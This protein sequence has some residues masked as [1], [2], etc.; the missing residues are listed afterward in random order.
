MSFANATNKL[1]ILNIKQIKVTAKWH[2]Q[3]S[4]KHSEANA[5]KYPR[6]FSQSN[7]NLQNENYTDKTF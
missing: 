6:G 5:T 1:R 2:V 4:I 7:G 3:N